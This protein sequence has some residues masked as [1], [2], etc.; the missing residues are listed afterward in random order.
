MLTLVLGT[1]WV[2][3]TRQVLQMV[4]EDVARE[5]TGTIL[6]VPELISH[7][8]ERRLCMAAGDTASRYAEVLSFTRLARRSAEYLGTHIP[9]TLDKGGR[10]V[11]MASAVRQ[12]HSKLK[13]YA[14]VETKPEFLQGLLDGVDVFKRCCITP[15]DLMAASAQTQGSL[16]QKLEELS[17]ILEAYNAICQR[18]KMDPRDLMTWVL[19]ELEASDFGKSHRLYVDG[20][21]DFT[22]QHL[23]ILEYF[24]RQDAPVV[25]SLPCDTPGSTAMAFEKAG[26]TAKELLR[27]AQKAGIAVQT[28]TVPRE[29]TPTA[30][31]SRLLFQGKIQPGQGKDCLTVVSAQSIHAECVLAAERIMEL[32]AS[33]CRYRD[34]SLVCADMGSYRGELEMVLKRCH[35]P[36]Y[37]AGTEEV[38]EKSVIT[39]VLSAMDAALG[40]LEQQDVLRY[41]K[42]ALSPLSL[43][44]C[45]Q[46][47]AYVRLWNIS[48]SRWLSPWTGHPKGLTDVWTTEDEA[49]LEGLNG[50]RQQITG[51]LDNLRKAFSKATSVARQVQALYAFVEGIGLADRLNRLA[52][53]LDAQ[54]D[55]R[56]AQI[57]SQLWEILL[58]AMEQLYDV[59]GETAWD[60]ETF[61]RLFRLLISQ[62]DV[63]TIP[64]VLDGVTAGPVSA[65]RCQESRHLI[66]LGAS[67]G[68]LPGYT[69]STGILSDRECDALRSLGMPLTGGAMEGI[70]A[71]FGEI[72]GVF[73]GCRET[74]WVSC[75]GGQPSFVCRRLG[76]LAGGMESPGEGLGAALTDPQEAAAY[77]AGRNG[78]T[79]AQDLG[80]TEDYNRVLQQLSFNLGTVKREQIQGLYGKSL[81]LSASQIDL[82]AQCRLAYFLK[83]GLKIR[84][85][86]PAQVDPAEFGTYVHWVLEQTVNTV[87]DRGGFHE[88]SLEDTLEIAREAAESYGKTHFSQLDSQRLRYLFQRNDQ[89]LFWIVR[90]LWEE[91]QAS[92][93]APAGTEVGF[94]GDGDLPPVPVSGRAMEAQLRGFVDR[95]DVWQEGPNRYF[96]VVD[97]KTGK[98]DFDYCDI[99]NGLGLQMLL[100]L[101][102]LEEQGKSLLG[103]NP[104]GVGVQYFP[105]RA[106]LMTSDGMLTDE[107]ARQ[108]REK[109]WK[110][111]GLLLEDMGI[112]QAMEPETPPKRLSYKCNK[113]GELS[114]D[115]ASREDLKTLRDYVFSLVGQM[116]DTIAA[117]EVAPNPYTRGESHNVCRFCPYGALCHPAQVEG[118]R[119]YKA[120]SSKEF[121]E[122]VA[123]EVEK[124]G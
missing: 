6:L 19:E 41:I 94:G 5:R 23:A 34:I 74:M 100:Y 85:R 123:Q 79:Q 28:V 81:N 75:S 66:L 10:I 45:D 102:S 73:C 93:F 40:G 84:E 101:F 26:A 37:V 47:E 119:N 13:A 61:T 109:L 64:P 2:A 112:L 99:Y 14:S 114:G 8:M 97:Y 51:P 113:E 62:Y 4:G 18:G 72:Y 71:E 32:A 11:A 86:K 22:R 15:A 118:R 77:L 17:L 90:E 88:V 106:P 3:N 59:L 38:L 27:L 65:M 117:G 121:W 39:T 70:Q 43:E 53:T 108:Q 50:W 76:E 105:A 9:P 55:N 42:S 12:L 44:E 7:E 92:A 120:I 25:V 98:K 95:V 111:K 58:G 33:G 20:F 54:G 29:E 124:H 116:V 78:K 68:S 115:L 21:P 69:G 96:R 16:A 31:V 35:I 36:V 24:I 82:Q 57:L 48:G 87:M 89:E 122:A 107:E 60:S 1:D 103:D 67:E 30:E 104:H 91:L 110:R 46:L 56:E 52:K 83:Y 49:L 63:G 80:L